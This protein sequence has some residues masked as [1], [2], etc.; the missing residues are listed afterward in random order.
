M[1]AREI[2]QYRFNLNAL[3]GL[4]N[5]NFGLDN[6]GGLV[7]G[8]KRRSATEKRTG[9]FTAE[10]RECVDRAGFIGRWFAAA[11]TTAII[12]AS[13]GVAP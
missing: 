13:W 8:P 1:R 9:L 4:D 10:V 3:S 6:D 7:I 11:G 2:R 12:Y 5:E